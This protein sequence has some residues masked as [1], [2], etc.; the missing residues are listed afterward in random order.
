MELPPQI[1]CFIQSLVRLSNTVFDEI[2]ADTK[3]LGG[4]NAYEIDIGV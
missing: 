3:R 2:V 1:N 4:D